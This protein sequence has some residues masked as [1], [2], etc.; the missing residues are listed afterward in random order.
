MGPFSVT[1]QPNAMGGREVGG[2]ANTLAC[3]LDIENADHRKEV[4]CFWKAPTMPERQGL[5]AV[6]LFRAVENGQIKALWIIH[7]NPAVTM[8]DA[9]KVRRAI[10]NC[11]FTVVSDVTDQTDTARVADVLLPAAGWA[12]TVGTVTNSDRMISRQRAVL[13]PPGQARAD[14]D[15]LAEVGRHMGWKTAFKYKSPAEI[16]REYAAMSSIAKSFS[17]DFDISGYSDLTDEEYAKLEPTRW[18]VAGLETGGRFFGDGKF[19]HPD[20]KA[21]FVQ[22]THRPPIAESTPKYPFMLNTGRNRDQWHTMTRSGLSPRLSA[23]LA[24]PFV[25]VHP[26]DAAQLG[27]STADLVEVESSVGRGIFR[28]RTTDAVE[29]G[30]VFAPIHWTG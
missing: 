8:P 27:L 15:I 22:V 14:W 29:R 5:K 28:L 6:D 11:P 25:E 7:T 20:G 10:A 18:P 2:L 3:H 23:H 17:K 19:F 26:E 16:F 12:E 9:D 30:Q 21:W 4:Q 1:G 13:T 24:E